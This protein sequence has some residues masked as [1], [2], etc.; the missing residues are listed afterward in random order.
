MITTYRQLVKATIAKYKS[1][2][3]LSK[4]PAT[5]AIGQRCKYAPAVE[6][7]VGCAIGCHLTPEN[8]ARLDNMGNNT[9]IKRL[10]RYDEGRAI[11]LE[12]IALDGLDMDAITHFQAIHDQAVDVEDYRF[13]LQEELRQIEA[14]NRSATTGEL[15]VSQELPV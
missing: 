7:S 3:A 1:A 10:A 8:G 6:G 14:G 15:L 4:L 5:I 11:L 9:T 2:T 12:I 13:W